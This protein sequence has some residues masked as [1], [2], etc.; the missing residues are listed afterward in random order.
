MYI[1]NRQE[2][3]ENKR[4]WVT[5]IRNSLKNITNALWKWQINWNFATILRKCMTYL[6]LLETLC[7]G[8]ETIYFK[9]VLFYLSFEVLTVV[10]STAVFW[11]GMSYGLHWWSPIFYRN[12]PPPLT[13]WS[14]K[15]SETTRHR[16]PEDHKWQRNFNYILSNMFL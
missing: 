1:Q 14:S 8:N 16:N 15:M 12:V 13:G 5:E 3:T 6:K 9:T 2:W 4:D 11:V 10:M 7:C